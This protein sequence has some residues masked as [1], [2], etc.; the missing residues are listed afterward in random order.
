MTALAWIQRTRDWGVFVSNRVKEIR[1]LSDVSSCEHVPSEKNSADFLSRGRSAQ[2]LIYL[3]WWEGP[4][5]LSENPVQCPRSK[6]VP[7]EEAVNLELRKSVLV[8]IP[9]RELRSL[10]G[11][12]NIFHLT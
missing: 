10:T 1:N 6:R 12:P 8:I 5:W 2:Q 7:D 9:L 3:R 11:T 4:S